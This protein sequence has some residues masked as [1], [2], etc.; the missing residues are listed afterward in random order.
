MHLVAHEQ[1]AGSAGC[2]ACPAPLPDPLSC[3]LHLTPAG[4]M[5]DSK[6]AFPQSNIYHQNVVNYRII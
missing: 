1:S 5:D 3:P 4:F 2:S 6:A